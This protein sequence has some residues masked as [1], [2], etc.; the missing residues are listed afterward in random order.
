VAHEPPAASLLPDA[1]QASPAIVD[2]HETYMRDGFGP[3]MAKFIALTSL[4]GP[5]PAGFADQP[6]DPA[7][8]GFPTEDDGDCDEVIFP[9]TMAAS[10]VATS[11]GRRPGCVRGEA[12]G[13]PRRLVRPAGAEHEVVEEL[14]RQPGLEQRRVEALQGDVAAKR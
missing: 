11:V 2:I 12:A 14:G 9:A 7:A 1:E 10:W 8:F 4:K 6:A 13:G 5:I 3:A